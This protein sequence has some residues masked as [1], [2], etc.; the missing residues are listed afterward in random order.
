LAEKF[1]IFSNLWPHWVQRYAYNGKVADLQ[2]DFLALYP[3]YLHLATTTNLDLAATFVGADAR[4]GVRT[5]LQP[6][7]HSAKEAE[8]MG[9]GASNFLQV[10]F[11]PE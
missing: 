5:G 10:S 6:P 8:W 7:T 9:H 3:L 11:F 2:G 1:W 4:G